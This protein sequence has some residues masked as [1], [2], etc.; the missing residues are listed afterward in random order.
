MFVSIS[1]IINLSMDL[2]FSLA[3][4]Q[5]CRDAAASIQKGN[6]KC[7]KPQT[8]EKKAPPWQA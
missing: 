4:H 8:A 1:A 5:V 2:S 6:Y 3:S 7:R